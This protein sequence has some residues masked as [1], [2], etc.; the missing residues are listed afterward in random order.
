M[1]EW[2][3]PGEVARRLRVTPGAVRLWVRDG[4]LRSTRTPGGKYRIDRASVE[5]LETRGEVESPKDAADSRDGR[6][7]VA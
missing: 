7:L 5:E 4:Y 1:P 3:T 6:E 2:M